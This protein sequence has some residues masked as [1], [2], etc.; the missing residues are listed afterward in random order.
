MRET[1]LD[2]AK[3]PSAGVPDF[4]AGVRESIARLSP[5]SFVWA[6]T[7]STDWSKVGGLKIAADLVKQPDLPKRLD[8]VRAV[9]AGLSFEPEMKLSVRVRWA[10]ER[11]AKELATAM[12]DRFKEAKAQ[13]TVSGEWAD[14]VV[15][16]DPP[17]DALGVLKKALE[18]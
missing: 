5:S 3:K 1:D 11:G 10:D 2:A 7:D 17:K 13:V 18:R 4:R 14:A 9:A 6:A 16:F 15:P 8:G 12:T